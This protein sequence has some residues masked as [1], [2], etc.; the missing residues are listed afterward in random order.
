[1]ET[2]KEIRTSKRKDFHRV[3]SFELS[4]MEKGRLE[5]VRERCEGLDISSRGFGLI[6]KCALKR[7]SVIRLYLPVDKE[8]PEL[9]VFSEVIWVQPV[10]SHVKAGLRFL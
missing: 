7:G 10:G 5:N 4:T 1:M 6:T 3:V 2:I 8:G 9:P